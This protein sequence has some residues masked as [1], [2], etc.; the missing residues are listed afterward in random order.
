MKF[1]YFSRKISLTIND[2]RCVG[3]GKCVG[4]CPHRVLMLEGKLV[5]VVS[6]G[7]CI[8]C[9]ACMV[10]CPFGAIFV[11]P[12]VGCANAVLGTKCC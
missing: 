8:E 2:K 4:V 5:K 3:C 9:G 7:Q 10:N 6:L 1:R 12:G 11:K